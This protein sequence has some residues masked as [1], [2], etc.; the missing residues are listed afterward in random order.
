MNITITEVRNAGS[1][2]ADNTSMDVEI[3]HPQYGWIP[4]GLTDYDTDT[5]INNDEVMALV[6]SSFATYV[7]PTQAELDAALVAEVRGQRDSLLTEVDN[8]VSNP[9]RWAELSYDAQADWAAYR[10]ALLDVPQQ[11]GFP[12]NVTWPTKPGDV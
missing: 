2:N 4:Y 12:A 3:N 10:K 6:G 1:M 5:T 8:H 9:L 11:A 7:P